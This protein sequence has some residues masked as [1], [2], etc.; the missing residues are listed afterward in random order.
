MQIHGEPETG[1]L[2]FKA[3]DSI[4]SLMKRLGHR[5]TQ[6]AYGLDTSFE[7]EFG[8]EG[9]LVI[10]N[11]EYDAL[12]GLGH[13]C[14]HNL[15]ATCSIA[16]FLASA[17]I[18]RRSGLEGRVRLLGT[19]AEENGG[20]KIR[21]IKAGAYEGAD[22]CLMAHPIGDVSSEAKAKFDGLSSIGSS[23]RRQLKVCFI[24]QSAHAGMSPWLGKNA[25]DAVVSSYVNIS[26]LRQQLSSSA[27][28]QGTI[29]QG[30]VEP[31]LIP[32]STAVEYYLR[33]I[34]A[35]QMKQ[36]TEKVEACFQAGALATGC[37]VECTHDP[38]VPL[39]HLIN[40][41]Y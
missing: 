3:H 38:W 7:V 20:D 22:A 9:S 12:P 10:S 19:P 5:V 39:R 34:N 18:L 31:D 17:E 24:G 27:R 41:L 30:G 14:G 35:D 26:L 32:D 33:D 28:V 4:C 13:A 37:K 2:E 15:I 21:L 40:V 1:Y 29:R 25:L 6:H 36:L 23:A 8:K 11:A 16:A